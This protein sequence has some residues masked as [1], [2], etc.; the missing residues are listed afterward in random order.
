[1]KVQNPQLRALFK[2]PQRKSYTLIAF[3]AITVGIFVVF[4]LRPTFKK[5]SSLRKEIKDKEEFLEK[6]NDKLSTLNS[7]IDEK[8]SVSKEV[9]YF[10]KVFPTEQKEGFMVANLAEIAEENNLILKS[11]MFMDEGDIV[12]TKN[13]KNVSNI[14]NLGV[15]MSLEGETT[16]IERF[17]DYLESFPMIFD[18]YRNSYATED[19]ENFEG[20]IEDFAAIRSNISFNT[21]YWQSSLSV[22]ETGDEAEE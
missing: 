9:A 16:D 13:T 8:E 2:T 18:L 7:L 22:S 6:M 3:T 11:V 12:E 5:V 19:I 21:H 15:S 14:Y 4:S 20:D 1:M 17:T 10:N